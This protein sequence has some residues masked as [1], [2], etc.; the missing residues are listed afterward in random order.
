[1]RRVWLA[2]F[3]VSVACDGPSGPDTSVASLDL[4]ISADELVSGQEATVDVTARTSDGTVVPAEVTWSSSDALVVTVAAGVVTA[5]GAGNAT[6]AAEIGAV[7]EEIPVRVHEGAVVG[8]AGGTVTGFD[9][10]VRLAVPAGALAAETP[11]RL[12][13]SSAPAD[14]PV[15][16]A[17]SGVDVDFEGT[18]ALPAR[19]TLGYDPERAPIGLPEARLGL[20]ARGDGDW[21]PA[22]DP[23]VD[24]AA[25]EASGDIE[26]PGAFGAGMVPSATPCTA[27]AH[28]LFDFRI[29]SFDWDGPG[30]L[31][32]E[33]TITA[34]ESGCSF[35]ERLVIAGGPTVRAVFF[36]DEASEAWYYTSRD[37][38]AIT[39]LA[40]GE[41]GGAMVLYAPSGLTRVVW[42][43]DADDAHTQSGET[44]P[45]GVTWTRLATGTYTRSP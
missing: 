17:T 16:L 37:G 38:S 6:V 13:P 32:G 24:P 12:L 25:H 23:G 35:R 10:R 21:L 28:R 40:G 33:A 11:I 19:L 36:H 18:L 2:L 39:R 15:Y 44:S 20:I 9:G 31:A 8:P 41:D 27:P 29:G 7:R 42:E 34:E 14:D 22:A 45:D 26:G 5:V 1:M 3:L 30:T 43:H 4:A